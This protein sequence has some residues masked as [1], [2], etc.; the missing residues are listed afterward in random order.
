M[1]RALAFLIVLAL[2]PA[3]WL[4]VTLA[5]RVDDAVSLDAAATST[6]RLPSGFGAFVAALH[7]R[8]PPTAPPTT[9]TT[10]P[11][12]KQV[13]TMRAASV[14]ATGQVNGYPCGG[15]LPP[16]RVLRCE[17]GG[18]PTAQN[19]RSSASGLWQILDGT[20]AGFGGYD[21]AY[22]APPDVQNSK[23]R[24]LWRG[25]AGASHWEVCL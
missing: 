21:R 13:T 16:C 25:G 4:A 18:N 11:R 17:S 20:W 10:A 14:E 8:T 24:E 22:L 3:L 9:T 12:A 1:T 7:D 15:D 2:V 6:D 19:R 23:A 5:G